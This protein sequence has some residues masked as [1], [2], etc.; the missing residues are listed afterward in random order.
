MASG[1]NNLHPAHRVRIVVASTVMLSFISFWRAAAIVLN[2][3]GSS[4]FYAGAIAEQAVGKAA[5]W[6]VLAVMLFSFAVRSVY[7]ES[8]SMF[9]RGG[10]YRVVKEALGGNLAK[11]SV[12]ALMF[13]YVLTGPISGVSAGH[14]IAGLFNELLASADHHGWIPSAIH[15]IA[16]SP[17]QF[18]ENW[19][20]AAFGIGVTLYFWWENVKGI[21][22]SSDKALKVMQ[23]TTVMVVL[24]LGWS[25]ITLLVRGGQLPPLP[26]PHNLTF[27]KD[28]LGFLEHSDWPRTFG[29]L[30]IMI[31][32]GHS[33][34]A[35]SGEETLAQVYREIEA[36][37]LKNF[38]RAAV[39]VGAY[40]FMF[41]G[42]SALLAVMIIPDAVRIPVYKDNIISGLAMYMVGPYSLRVI[43]RVFVVVVGFLMLSGAVNTSI[44]GSNGVLNRVS[45][46]GVLTDWFRRPHPKYGTSYRILNLIVGLQ[47]ITILASRGDVFLLGEAYAFGVIWSFTFNSLSMLVLRFKYHGKREWKMPPNIPK[48][49]FGVEVPVGLMSVFVILL[50]AALTNL[51]TK[52]IATIAGLIF[53]G[54]FFLTFTISERFNQRK[55]RATEE[56]MKEHFQL[57]HQDTIER[58]SVGIQPGNVLVTVRDYNTLDHLKWALERTNTDEQDVVVL[59]A[60]ITGF[61]TGEYEL[62]SEQI[63]SDYEQKLFTRAVSI[64]EDLGKTVSLLVVPAREPFTAIMQTANNLESSA[65]VAGLSS[66]MDAEEQAFRLGQ[67]WEAMPPPKRQVV[68]QVVKPDGDVE[69]FRIGPHTP[70]MRT[71]DVHLVHRM[72]LN[73]R[74]HPGTEDVHHS[75]IVSLALTRLMRDYMRE[76]DEILRALIKADARRLRETRPALHPNEPG[77]QPASDQQPPPS[78]PPTEPQ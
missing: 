67:A 65:V 19:L 21:E 77:Q 4:A 31:A 53:T 45:E 20:A 40:S 59:T 17:P 28:A 30:G 58:E 71:E 57:E 6:F 13:D 48:K 11:I 69:T 73:V 61:G 56:E 64:A 68:F 66:K 47:L 3:M 25:A 1:P 44:I 36:P 24:L 32:F 37:K 16:G 29:L 55:H 74:K 35:M 62:E 76:P 70:T 78:K 22:E 51:L 54:A 42:V 60:R 39:L 7:V 14:Y 75:S 15:R 12:S 9:V 26:L 50:L 10:V 2:D 49:V 43:F 34:L 41:T 38:K 72:W 46:D 33:I 5:P 23:V 18:N 63:F 8:A 27:S 52:R